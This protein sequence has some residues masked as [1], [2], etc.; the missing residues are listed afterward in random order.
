M[1][2]GADL[3]VHAE[4]V[5]EWRLVAE[6]RVSAAERASTWAAPEGGTD[7]LVEVVGRVASAFP[8]VAVDVV[9]AEADRVVRFTAPA[10][11]E[12]LSRQEFVLTASS[13]V[14]AA[15]AFD[16]AAAVRP[17]P[18]RP[19]RASATPGRACAFG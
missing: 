11:E 16:A 18:G 14:R 17:G 19:S 3:V 9:P 8:L 10:Y 6:R 12:G 13:V 2:P 15:L 1:T 7:V 5:G 4:S